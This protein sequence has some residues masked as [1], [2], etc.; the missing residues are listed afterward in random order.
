MN[1]FNIKNLLHAQILTFINICRY[2]EKGVILHSHSL[3]Q[4][5][6]E[7]AKE[8]SSLGDAFILSAALCSSMGSA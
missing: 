1:K 6:A 7:F 2:E 3:L 8:R 5:H 4:S